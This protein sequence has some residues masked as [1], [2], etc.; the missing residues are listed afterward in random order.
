MSLPIAERIHEL[1]QAIDALGP[2]WRPPLSESQKRQTVDMVLAA[3]SDLALTDREYQALAHSL[4]D[5][6][7]AQRLADKIKE[8]FNHRDPQMTYL[9]IDAYGKQVMSPALVEVWP[10]GHHSPIHSH[11]GSVGI[12]KCLA[13]RIDIKIYNELRANARVTD[14]FTLEAGDTT[15]LTD[16]ENT[17]HTLTCPRDVPFA[18]TVQIYRSLR[19]Q[20]FDYIGRDFDIH[21][22][23][24]KNDGSWQEIMLAEGLDPTQ[25]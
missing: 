10:A 7:L 17:V 1:R 14:A 20:A 6:L 23:V 8:Q 13:G 22:F 18:V 2:E 16:R 19:G 11:A 15:Y 25:G 3:I 24:P 4:D 21:P 5:G 9:R 12:I